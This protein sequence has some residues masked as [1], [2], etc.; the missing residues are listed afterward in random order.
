MKREEASGYQLNLPV[1]QVVLG[2]LLPAWHGDS[3]LPRGAVPMRSLLPQTSFLMHVLPGLSTR[4][5]R[6]S[7]GPVPS[8]MELFTQGPS[9]GFH[10]DVLTLS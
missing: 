9:S 8:P 5:P 7:P 10:F 4:T 1:W 2:A 3:G 6:E